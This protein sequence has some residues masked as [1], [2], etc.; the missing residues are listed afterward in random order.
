MPAVP[1]AISADVSS[2]FQLGPLALL[3]VLYAKRVRTLALGGRDVPGWRQACFYG[4]F[5]VIAAALTSL[6]SASQELLY[7]HMIEHLLLGDIAALLIVLGL[8]GPLIAPILKI[9]FFN[10]LRVLP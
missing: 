10:R 1:L 9:T 6:G 4:G 5:V 8:T 7:V 3:A 2:L